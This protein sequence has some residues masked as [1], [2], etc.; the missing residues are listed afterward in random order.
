MDCSVFDLVQQV[1]A[2]YK[3]AKEKHRAKETSYN[4]KATYTKEFYST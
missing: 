1:K 4:V 3:K 2:A